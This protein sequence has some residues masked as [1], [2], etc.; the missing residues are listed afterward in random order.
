MS[1]VE[2]DVGCGVMNC[3]GTMVAATPAKCAVLHLA[4]NPEGRPIALGYAQLFVC[5]ACNVPSWH[6]T[7]RA[8][9]DIVDSDA[10]AGLTDVP[11]E[12]GGG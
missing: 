8:I 3:C 2:A 11:C 4:F 6:T 9:G 7:W 12:I 1:K 10:H 5:S